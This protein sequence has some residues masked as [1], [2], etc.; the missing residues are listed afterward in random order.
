MIDKRM[1]I[2]NS[3]KINRRILLIAYE[4]NMNFFTD[5]NPDNVEEATAQFRVVQQAYEVL[6]DPQERAWYDKHREAILR[7]G[8]LNQIIF[9]LNQSKGKNVLWR[10]QAK[11][12]YLSLTSQ[13]PLAYIQRSKESDH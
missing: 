9:F 11:N 4:T 13:F 3:N 12:R 10:T 8:M 2:V 7:G 5:K 1:M 6:T